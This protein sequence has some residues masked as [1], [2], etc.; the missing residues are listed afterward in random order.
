MDLEGPVLSDVSIISDNDNVSWGREGDNITLSFTSNE[1]IQTPD[2]TNISIVGLTDLVFTSLNDN[3]TRWQVTG[4]VDEDAVSGSGGSGGSG[5]ADFSI[6]VTDQAGNTGSSVADATGG[7]RVALDVEDPLVNAVNIRSSNDNSSLAKAGDNITLE[8][9][10][11]EPIQTPDPVEVTVQGTDPLE[12]T[13]LD[14]EGK[15]WQGIGVVQQDAAGDAF[16][17]IS[18]QDYAGNRGSP[19][20]QTTDQTSVVLDTQPPTLSQ[21]SLFS[22]NS[23]SNSL[24]KSGDNITLRF[25]A[26][27]AIFTPQVTLAGTVLS[28][29]DLEY[30]GNDQWQAVHQ[31]QPDD[32]ESEVSFSISFSDVTGN[33]GVEV[34]SSDD[35]V[36]FDPV[37]IDLT[38]PEVETSSVKI[39]SDNPTAAVDGLKWAKTGETIT[40]EFDTDEKVILPSVMING[41]EVYASTRDGDNTG[42]KWKADYYVMPDG[43]DLHQILNEEN[44]MLW[45]DASNIDGNNNS[46]LSD[47]DAVGEWKDL[48]GNGYDGVQTSVIRKPK[49]Q[50]GNNLPFIN[51]ESSKSQ[52]FRSSL[53][54]DSSNFNQLTVIAVFSVDQSSDIHGSGIWGQDDGGWDRFLTIGHSQGSGLSNGSGIQNMTGLTEKIGQGIIITESFY[55]EDTDGGSN[56]YLDGALINTFTSNN[57]SGHSE[58]VIGSLNQLDGLGMHDGKIA[59]MLIFNKKLN[60]QERLII[61]SYLSSKWNQCP[62]LTPTVTGPRM[63]MNRLV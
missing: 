27:E 30:L 52:E 5:Y 38:P 4:T 59:E 6:S 7:E 10:F 35:E 58:L 2:L 45:L 49:F 13:K 33:P 21:F 22:N 42:K 48:S 11:D 15:H 19:L 63:P 28:N 23:L 61:N 3:N 53:N 14:Q 1:T 12:F 31:V 55:D 44:L 9:S 25:T 8:F 40:L 62:Q 17:S 37:R 60:D 32:P 29:S 47:G 50:L 34:S 39:S 36:A 16:I 46:S 57:N 20:T 41:K 51:F 18:V 24:A 56:F 54:I 26:S 43:Y